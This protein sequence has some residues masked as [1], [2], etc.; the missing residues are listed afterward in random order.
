MCKKAEG[1][2]SPF[3]SLVVVVEDGVDDPIDALHIDKADHGPGAA[4]HFHKAA[5]DGVG[6]AQLGPEVP[7][8]TAEAPP[9]GQV[10]LPPFHPRP[11]G[12][13][14][15][16]PA[17]PKGRRG[18]TAAGGSIDRRRVGLHCLIVALAHLREDIPPLMHPAALRG[19]ARVDPRP[20]RGPPRPTVPDH[21]PQVVSSQPPGL[22]IV[23]QPFPRGLALARAA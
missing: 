19:E 23:E 14:P 2:I 6:G 13:L 3:M 7:R 16:G 8:E 22:Q 15:A 18:L 17:S 1:A 9:L 20:R 5:L 21:Q 12:S 4:T 11:L 10:A